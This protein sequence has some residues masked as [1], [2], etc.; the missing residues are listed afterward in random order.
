MFFVLIK[1]FHNTDL[2]NDEDDNNEEEEDRD[3]SSIVSGFID[4]SKISINGKELTREQKYK[5]KKI[6]IDNLDKPTCSKVLSKCNFKR[7]NPCPIKLELKY[8]E[9]KNNQNI[10]EN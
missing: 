10:N 4:P 3:D 7:W 2:Q 6:I 1:L 8:A 9:V 5:M